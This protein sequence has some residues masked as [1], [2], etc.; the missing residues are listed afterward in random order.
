MLFIRQ[1][2]SGTNGK[3]ENMDVFMDRM[4]MCNEDVTFNYLSP[5]IYRYRS[6]NGRVEHGGVIADRKEPRV[7]RS[8]VDCVDQP[9]G[10][11]HLDSVEETK[12]PFEQ[13]P[14]HYKYDSR[15]EMLCVERRLPTT[16]LRSPYDFIR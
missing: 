8:I 1:T 5:S 11:V 6:N 16:H 4:N 10:V 2:Q 14:R 13:P 9:F 15:S 7:I 12:Q 3:R